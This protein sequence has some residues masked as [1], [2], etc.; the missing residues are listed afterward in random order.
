MIEDRPFLPGNKTWQRI[1]YAVGQERNPTPEN[2]ATAVEAIAERNAE[3]RT[4]LAEAQAEVERLRRELKTQYDIKAEYGAERERLQTAR[5]EQDDAMCA[6]QGEIRSLEA[7]V[8]RL[9]AEVT[10][11]EKDAGVAWETLALSRGWTKE[12][13]AAVSA[14]ID[15]GEI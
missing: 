7:D 11:L 3:R 4:A 14:A 15:K 13:W 9:R 8:E 2:V 6:Y 1:A 10:R 12:D 5:Q